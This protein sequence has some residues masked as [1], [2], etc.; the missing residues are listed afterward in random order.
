MTEKC[1]ECGKDL[2]LNSESIYCSKCDVLLDK[3]FDM[4]ETNL[5]VYKELSDSEIATL[6]KFDREDIVNLYLKLF[7]SY[8]EDGD[9]DQYEAAVLN[10]IQNIFNLTEKDIGSDKVVKF[11]ASKKT[12]KKQKLLECIK[13]GKPV[14]KEDFVFCPYCGFRLD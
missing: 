1:A 11:D 14:L 3:K 10:K 9:F 5:I 2:P 7:E 13:C 8:R 4:V 6:N 12:V